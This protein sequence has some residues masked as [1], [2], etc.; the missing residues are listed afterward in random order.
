M[1]ENT[2]TFV[3]ITNADI[4]RIMR[5]NQEANNKAHNEIIRRLDFTNGKVKTIKWIATTGISLT[6]IALG[7][8]FQHLGK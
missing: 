4:Y 3:K 2:D 7:F 1:S 6:I 8:L 5:E